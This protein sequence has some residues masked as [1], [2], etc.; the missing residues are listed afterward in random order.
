MESTGKPN[1]AGTFFGVPAPWPKPRGAGHVF[2]SL[3]SIRCKWQRVSRWLPTNV[4]PKAIWRIRQDA[5]PVFAVQ[6]PDFWK[7][8]LTPRTSETSDNEWADLAM[9]GKNN[10]SSKQNMNLPP[11]PKIRKGN[12]QTC[13]KIKDPWQNPGQRCSAPSHFARLT[14]CMALKQ[15]RDLFTHFFRSGTAESPLEYPGSCST[16]ASFGLLGF[17]PLCGLIPRKLSGYTW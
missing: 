6:F 15:P 9:T 16:L 2:F 8:L 1:R 17:S 10:P 3:R 7:R 13:W 14:S 12:K 5:I 4:G 11:L